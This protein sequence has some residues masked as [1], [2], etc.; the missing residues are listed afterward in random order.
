MP[1]LDDFK[2]IPAPRFGGAVDYQQGPGGVQDATKVIPG[3]AILAQDTRFEEDLVA[4]RFGNQTTMT[5]SAS[6]VATGLDVLE[7]IGEVNPGQIPVVFDDQG[8]LLKESPVG[9]ETLVALTPPFP[10]PAGA[11]MQTS[12]QQNRLAMAFSDGVAGLV[13]PLVLDGRTGQLNPLSQNTIGA[14]WQKGLYYLIGDLVRSGDGR[15]WRCKVSA[16]GLS[17][18]Q[19]P[20]WPQGYGQFVG[21]TWTPLTVTDLL[22]GL[23]QWEEWTPNCTSFLPA[24]DVTT[25]APSVTDNPGGGT[26]ASGKDVYVKLTYVIPQTGES[27]RSAALVFSNTQATDEIIISWANAGGGPFIPRWMAEI[28]LQPALFNPFYLNVY[29]AIV[30]TGAPAPADVNYGLYAKEQSLG[31]TINIT[32]SSV[33]A[34]GGQSVVSVTITGPGDYGFGPPPSVTFSGG[35]GSGAAGAALTETEYIGLPGHFLQRIMYVVGVNI[36]A[37]GQGYTSPPTVTFTPSLHGTATGTAVLGGGGVPAGA[38]Y[39]QGAALSILA[40]SPPPAFRGS[41]GTRYMIILR[42]DQQGSLAPVDPD[43]PLP[44]TIQGQVIVTILA[45]ERNPSGL[46]SATVTDIT[47]FAVGQEIVVQGCTGDTT[48]NGSFALTSVEGTDAPAGILQ[49]TDSAHL[50]ASNDS[51]GAVELPPGLCPIA[52]LP[53][54]GA[55]DMLDIAAFTVATEESGGPYFYIS[56]ADIPNPPSATLV[57]LEGGAASVQQTITSITRYA[58]GEVEVAVANIA[59]YE[60]G[61]VVRVQGCTGD[62][63]FNGEFVLTGVVPGSGIAGALVFVSFATAASSDSTGTITGLT[64]TGT[65]IAVLSPASAVSNFAAGQVV[66]IIGTSNAAFNNQLAVIAQINQNV[67]TLSLA[68]A[69]T[70]TGGSISVQPQ[71]PSCGSSPSQAITSITRDASGN[72][73]AQVPNVEGWTPGQLINVFSVPDASY[74][75]LQQIVS[76]TLNPDGL[77]GVL[78]WYDPGPQTTSAGGFVEGFNDFLINF[79]DSLLTSEADLEV[80]DQ[81]SSMPAPL[82]ADLAWIPSLA[83]M[84]YVTGEDDA[85]H[86]S[87]AGDAE[88]LSGPFS[89][90]RVSDR[91]MS[92]A[93]AVRELESGEVIALKQDGGYQV[94]ASDLPPSQWNAPRRWDFYGPPCAAAIGLGSNFLAFPSQGEED[95]AYLYKAGAEGIEWISKE[96]STTWKRVNWSVAK[97][98]WTEVDEQA[99]EVHF[100]VALDGAT[101]VSHE[102]VCSYFAGWEFPEVLNRYGKLI[103]ARAARK[104]S[105][106]PIASK[107][108]KV[109]NR[110]IPTSDNRVA[111][112]QFLRGVN[113]PNPVAK[114]VPTKISRLA[115][116]VTATFSVAPVGSFTTILVTGVRDQSFNGQFGPATL[117]NPSTGVW[118]LTWKQAGPNSNSAWGAVYTTNTNLRVWMVQPDRYDDDGIGIDSQYE[119]AYAQDEQG[120][121]ILRFGGF[122]SAV[123]GAGEHV[124]T[125][126]T[127]DPS[128]TFSPQYIK[129][130]GTKPTR[131]ER[132]LRFDNEYGSLIYSNGAI[133]GSWFMLLKH[134]MHA[135][136]Y[137]AGRRGP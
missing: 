11:R 87:Q 99:K 135:N 122:R 40:P 46:V 69:G 84:A 68:V 42:K 112:R 85:F 33:I 20:I 30:A 76:V 66:A 53:P 26:L 10:L 127:D 88:N 59:G 74:D 133:P 8:N 48:F 77:S 129:L 38:S 45:I 93:I 89:G 134:V 108:A 78:G 71:L 1:N 21:S 12:Q 82:A 125:P 118:T 41:N 65:V 132:G 57:S 97:K 90:L 110:T 37:K 43:S 100:G 136:P 113:Q 2:P 126:V 62:A 111:N 58:G 34:P 96:Y 81:L 67:L 23:S 55:S 19:G 4:T 102:L 115:G 14:L 98:F 29:L 117:A 73:T 72:V 120:T 91:K 13:P 6:G 44:I 49:W 60:V 137:L 131:F 56:E 63:S 92:L 47:Q 128:Q 114:Y 123:D 104:W 124:I 107:T 75:G 109:V 39:P 22:G 52:F 116:T 101:E 61:Q 24:P 36:T 95:G 51:T 5:R 64:S 86:F 119:P 35:G 9:S 103:T 16:T 121:T 83:M 7:V 79:D 17:V 31:S 18:A 80:T 70:A 25:V 105:T 28:N 94:N 3:C 50:S 27:P 54:G 130:L 106:W 15:W 32:S